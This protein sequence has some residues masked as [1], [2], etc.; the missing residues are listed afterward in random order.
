MCVRR[1]GAGPELVWIHGLGE[2]SG[3][4]EPLAQ[5]LPGYTH[6]LVDLPGYGRSPW[7]DEVAD[8]SLGLLAAHLASWLADRPP[9]IL[10]GHSM[11]GVLATLV[12]E[13]LA[14][15]AVVNLD[16]NLTRGDCTFSARAAAEPREAFLA[17]GFEQMRLD[18]F[19]SAA[20]APALRGYH[21][22]LAMASPLVFHQHALDLV[23]LS[24]TATLAPRLA[25][26][27]V[28]K[29]FI[30][31]VPNGICGASR[32]ELEHLGVPWI[33]IEPAGHWVFVDQPRA[34][35]D[36]IECELLAK[37]PP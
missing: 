37:L 25:A 31:G 3:S 28:P 4:F 34:C 35:A 5:L 29:L 14:V 18:V 2:W 6:V 17:G 26:L 7:P 12:A 21:A 30:A 8:G 11:G 19:A 1:T 36:A 24:E 27:A 16:G 23:R 20:T 10:A 22:A 13:Q 9:A 33:G 32:N 15:R